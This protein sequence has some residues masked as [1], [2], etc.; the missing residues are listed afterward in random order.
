MINF[1]SSREG[2]P[3]ES[4]RRDRWRR[5]FTRTNPASDGAVVPILHLNGY[6][7]ANPSILSRAIDL[8]VEALMIG[9]GH[10]PFFVEPFDVAPECQQ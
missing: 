8:E 2:Q 3:N 5:R 4:V 9:Y 6:K 10:E 7:I 1:K